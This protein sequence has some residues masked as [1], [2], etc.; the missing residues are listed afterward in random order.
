M[1]VR[2]IR[3]LPVVIAT[4]LAAS[5]AGAFTPI[6]QPDAAYIA[7]TN[8]LAITDPDF[9]VMNSL[10]DGAFTT[11]FSIPMQARTVPASWATWGSPPFTETSTP[12]L[13]YSSGPSSVT[14]TFSAP[15]SIFGFEAQPN[16]FAVHTM[17]ANFYNGATLVGSIVQG[18]DGTAGARLFAASTSSMFTS[19]EFFSQG[20]FGVANL[21]Y[22]VV[23]GPFAALPM[24]LGMAGAAIRMRRRHK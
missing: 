12:R 15:V 21:R 4:G 10:S 24:L 17:T 13:L 19:V 2:I 16:A 5:H 3:F 11:N 23:P 1:N 20:D 8:L 9:T 6:A 7:N 18:V 22:N 14:F